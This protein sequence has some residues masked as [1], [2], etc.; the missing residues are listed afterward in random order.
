MHKAML[1]YGFEKKSDAE[2]K[3]DM[4]KARRVRKSKNFSLF[5]RQEY[6]RK[7]SLHGH[8]FRRDV[9]QDENYHNTSWI[10]KENDWMH[11]NYD[12]IF[13]GLAR[14]NDQIHGYAIR[15]LESL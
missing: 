2:L 7:R 3:A 5:H 6:L 11:K 13:K 10:Y 1:D 15:Y 12:T 14:T 8:M 9:M 4:E